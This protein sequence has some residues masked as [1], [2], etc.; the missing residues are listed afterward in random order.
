[1][2]TEQSKNQE[3]QFMLQL[4]IKNGLCSKQHA[5]QLWQK[6]QKI[7]IYDASCPKKFL[8]SQG[9][10]QV[11]NMNK[12]QFNP[13]TTTGGH[14][15]MTRSEQTNTAQKFG[16]Y[17][18]IEEI[19]R[20]G[21][22]VVYKVYQPEMKR[23][24]ALKVLNNASQTDLR[25][26][27]RF[28][29]EAKVTAALQHPHII[30][31]YEMSNLQGQNYFVMKHVTGGDFDDFIKENRDVDKSIDIL[32][33]VCQAL[34]HAHSHNVIHR[35]I[36]PS[37]ILLDESGEPYLADFGLAKNLDSK[38]MLTQTGATLGTAFY[39]A[40]EQIQSKNITTSID[41]Y[42]IGVMLY[43]ILTNELPFLAD[44][45]PALYKKILT[46]QPIPPKQLDSSIPQSL[47]HICLKCLQKNPNF[48]YANA[49][50]IAKDLQSYVANKNIILHEK[51][52]RIRI[53][54]LLQNKVMRTT[55]IAIFIVFIA[56]TAAFSIY[57][58]SAYK[59][60]QRE[61]AY[62]IYT[63]AQQNFDEN[64]IDVAQKMLEQIANDNSL[65]ESHFLLAKIY[66]RKNNPKRA[67]THI[68]KS[69]DVV[70]TPQGHHLKALVYYR[71][72]QYKQ[73][74]K[75]VNIGISRH[76]Y[77]EFYHLR[78]M[79]YRKTKPKAAKKD[80]IYAGKLEQK[81]L[82]SL[83]KELSQAQQNK[84]WGK[85]LAK[86][87]SVQYK[88]PSC[89]DIY[90][91]KSQI[92]FVQKQYD[93]AVHEINLAIKRRKQ[94]SYFL[95]KS[96]Y[97]RYAGYPRKAFSLLQEISGE[98]NTAAFYREH[99]KT[100]FLLKKM[101]QA[102]EAYEQI[103]QNSYTKE[104][105]VFLAQVFIALHKYDTAKKYLGNVIQQH[106]KD[107][108]ILYH[109]AYCLYK[110][111]QYTQAQQ[112]IE[113]ALR[114]NKKI[115]P[116]TLKLLAGKCY[117]K[118]GNFS[119]SIEVLEKAQDQLQSSVEL[120]NV[121]GEIYHQQKKYSDAIK[122]FSK[123]IELQP[124]NPKFYNKRGIL[125]SEQK[126]YTPSQKD[127]LKVVSL[128]PQDYSPIG[129]MFTQAF[130]N[131]NIRDQEGNMRSLLGIADHLYNKMEVDLFGEEKRSLTSLYLEQNNLLKLG[132][133]D[134]KRIVQFIKTLSSSTNKALITTATTGLLS[135]A[136]S[137]VVAQKIHEQLDKVPSNFRQK[138]RKIYTSAQR[139]YLQVQ[140]TL[141][142]VLLVR[143]YVARDDEALRSLYHFDD[144][145]NILR[146]ILLDDQENDIIRYYA[147]SALRDLKTVEAYT[148]LLQ[149]VKGSNNAA[150]LL[151]SLVLDKKDFH[152]QH[153]QKIPQNVFLK[154]MI[155][156]STK[157]PDILNFLLGDSYLAVR[158]SAAKNLWL[159]AN[160][161]AEKILAR[162]LQNKNV[163]VRRYCYYHFWSFSSPALEKIQSRVVQQYED[164]LLLG[165]QDENQDVVR[166]CL[167]KCANIE[168]T[169]CMKFAYT[170]VENASLLVRFQALTTIGLKGDL[171]TC[172][173][174][175][176]K[177]NEPLV[178]KMP[179]ILAVR[180]SKENKKANVLQFMKF[181][182]YLF[183]EENSDIRVIAMR[184]MGATHKGVA[185]GFLLRNLEHENSYNRIGALLGLANGGSNYTKTILP[186]FNNDPNP[187]VRSAAAFA[188][189]MG[190]GLNNR[191]KELRKYH[192]I[193]KKRPHGI[194]QA[195][196]LAYSNFVLKNNNRYK[197]TMKTGIW[198]EREVYKNYIQQLVTHFKELNEASKKRNERALRLSLELMPRESE[199]LFEMGMFYLVNDQL[200]KSK[201]FI[202]K[203]IAEQRNNVV[204][205]FWLATTQFRLAEHNK[206]LQTIQRAIHLHPWD[207][208][209]VLLKADILKALG[210]EKESIAA[211]KRLEL[212][213]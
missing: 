192:K 211:R 200:E 47:Q 146:N 6:W 136:H 122:A 160:A 167:M 74:L 54:Q 1:M 75:Y 12:T 5:L 4:M 152:I 9:F 17:Q 49:S 35:D 131:P 69:L 113:K 36:K 174:Y 28:F 19:A 80:K 202:E 128:N 159:T 123:C 93:D 91:Q 16:N 40:P 162:H 87:R 52:V 7:T 70:D 179:T 48:R 203:A 60:E 213:E 130:E 161:K 85:I 176:T 92:F 95:A 173:N 142:K 119:R 189:V 163:F 83:R 24:A 3:M 50:L 206:A 116:A 144:K 44:N 53:A 38:S 39:M 180:K 29:R 2:K 62:S 185:N 129:H 188:I 77:S 124:W 56:G 111:S 78:A 26:I 110:K 204:F 96:K 181:L 11:L 15:Q 201:S 97:L 199:Y 42:A 198:N 30:P 183:D 209:M 25:L 138:L 170:L 61:K 67:L 45:P 82:S 66:L 156:Q 103:D 177:P 63:Q 207:K 99:A 120:H 168:S 135:M 32:I 186:I 115:P 208:D 127:L 73:A 57:T 190:L 27:R 134:E 165:L 196:A 94:H 18:I 132:E 14:Q 86:L 102:K 172:A 84:E 33:K 71:Q 151:C 107:D 145:V 175:A 118:L 88:Y 65:W 143:H 76:R 121:L 23:Y 187:T 81:M 79:I 89:E 158:L 90:V 104:D 8:A 212:F 109:Y 141:I 58:F 64:K 100:L 154:S 153:L 34:D 184:E 55:L 191:W 197:F 193:I 59:G 105:H 21:M 140:S 108:E 125:Y 41:I 205:T 171:E 22:G 51:N 37:N 43:F 148:V 147:A 133:V 157:H 166:I 164:L 46:Q 195:A 178:I 137:S 210:Q 31:I 194:R 155:A 114:H 126:K 101:R 20:G 149:E 112:Y 139:R 169:K 150:L 10:S 106:D 98:E 13:H 117:Y 182:K 72:K 68:T